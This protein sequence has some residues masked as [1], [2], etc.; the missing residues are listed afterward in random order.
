[1]QSSL[2]LKIQLEYEHWISYTGI[3]NK[4]FYPKREKMIEG[5]RDTEL[6]I[7]I[8]KYLTL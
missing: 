5:F 6:L 7:I 2:I 8:S 4:Q 3:G 1:M